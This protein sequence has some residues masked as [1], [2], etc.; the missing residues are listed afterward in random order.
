MKALDSYNKAWMVCALK[1]R[2]NTDKGSG[3]NGDD[4]HASRILLASRTPRVMTAKVVAIWPFCAA[5]Q[6]S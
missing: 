3:E 2:N 1:K 6:S 5:R 4:V